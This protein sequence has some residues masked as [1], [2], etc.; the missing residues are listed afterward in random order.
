[1][2]P[3]G[4]KKGRHATASLN[5]FV[6]ILAD[7]PATL[8]TWMTRAELELGIK[9]TNFY[10]YKTAALKTGQVEDQAGNYRL[11]VRTK[12]SE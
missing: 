10:N 5:D 6:A 4:K 7:G 9:R 8:K 3:P 11:T 1:M 12:V 2:E